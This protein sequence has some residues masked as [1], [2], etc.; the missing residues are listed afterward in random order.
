MDEGTLADLLGPED[1]D[2]LERPRQGHEFDTEIERRKAIN[3]RTLLPRV[4]HLGFHLERETGEEAVYRHPATGQKVTVPG[5]S[6]HGSMGGKFQPLL[7]EQRPK[8]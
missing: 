8:D 5:W 4:H 3:D 6:I 7:A 2:L 1:A